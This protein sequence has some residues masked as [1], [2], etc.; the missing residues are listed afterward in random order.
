MTADRPVKIRFLGLFLQR[1]RFQEETDWFWT[2]FP[3]EVLR[4]FDLDN[5]VSS[6]IDGT[7]RQTIYQNVKTTEVYLYVL[8]EL[9][10]IACLVAVVGRYMDFV[11]D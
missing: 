5:F 11:P 8:F 4:E 9:G 2:G 3:E 6:S 1:M 7:G 10:S